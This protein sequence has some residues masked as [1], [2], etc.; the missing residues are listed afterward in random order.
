[1]REFPTA[2]SGRRRFTA[3]RVLAG[4][5]A[6]SLALASGIVLFGGE[7][8]WA[9]C[10][11]ASANNVT[12]TCTGTTINQGGG[13]PGTS[14]GADGYGIGN[15][16]GVAVNATGTSLSGTNNGVSLGDAMVT[17]DA[18][19]SIAGGLNGIS[20]A[21]GF[22]NVT[23][24]GS[25][26]APAATAFSTNAIWNPC[27]G[28]HHRR[29]GIYAIIGFADATTRQHHRHQRER[30]FAS[31]SATDNRRCQHRG[32]LAE[33]PPDW[34]ASCRQFRQHQGNFIGAGIDA[35]T[36]TTVRTMP[37]PASRGAVGIPIHG[38]S[39]SSMPAPSPVLPTTHCR[40][41]QRDGD[42]RRRRQHPVLN[43]II[44]TGF[45]NV[46]NSGTITGFV[47]TALPP[48]PTRR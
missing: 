15:E 13:A 17:N 11:P 40:Q 43:G 21:T 45:A 29:D 5:I 12:A 25:I 7:A 41:H 2:R 8:A 39:W 35:D 42:Q 31:T 46:T 9:D 14:A 3:R 30:H 6:R 32:R 48:A 1:M 44:T 16:T 4:A 36:N 38:S 26:T 47:S 18:G 33:F 20:T 10:T 22:A 27:R 23:N 34:L 28:H 19:A 24:S 37:A